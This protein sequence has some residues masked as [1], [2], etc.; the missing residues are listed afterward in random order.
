MNAEAAPVARSDAP[1]LLYLLTSFNNGGAEWGAVELVK[2][3]AFAGFDLTVAA[4]VRGAGAQL[5]EFAALGHGVE[6]LCE[7]SRPRPFA[8]MLAALRLRRLL[9]RLRPDVLVLSLP[10]ANLLGRLL[11]PSRPR[12]LV[13]SFEHNSRLARRTYELG[14][15]LTSGRV[16]WVIADC[17]ATAQ[18]AVARLYRRPP[19]RVD[20]APLVAFTPKRLSEPTPP[21]PPDRTHR[22]VSAGR[23]TAAK[24]QAY[25]VALLAALHRRDV[26]VE[27]TLFG[28]G[29]LRP[30]LQAASRRG[31]VE[32]RLS[33]P[34]HT[35]RWWRTPAD[36]FM[37][38]SRHEGLCISALDAMC[39]GLPVAAPLV[40]GLQDY[41]QAAKAL[42]LDGEDLEADA[43]RLATLLQDA[44]RLE[45]MAAAGRAMVAERYGSNVIH[46]QYAN[47]AVRL[48]SAAHARAKQPQTK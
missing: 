10:H 42:V 2:G 18:A 47:L 37:L 32:D 27:L 33:M 9:R 8:L 19:R 13:V 24:N 29:P 5:L 39:A 28:E 44:P 21:P 11:R 22:L 48:L 40:G 30:E 16:D 15:R 17:R 45:A 6:V 23:L 12:P 3:G 43:G 26:D 46:T 14:Y 36:L 35:P 31:G 25:L 1:R 20:V 38:A 34:G 7:A 4:L 41:G